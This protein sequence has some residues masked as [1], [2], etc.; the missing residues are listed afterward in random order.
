[1]GCRPSKSASAPASAQ[2]HAPAKQ[3]QRQFSFGIISD[4]QYCDMDDFR[5]S[6]AGEVR[7]Y[8]DSIKHLRKGVQLWNKSHPYFVAQLGDLIDEKNKRLQGQDAA[9][10]A[11]GEVMG[12]FAK[13]EMP[14]LH[15]MGNH[16][17]NNFNWMELR[18]MFHTPQ[19]EPSRGSFCVHKAAES[20]PP[21]QVT[22]ADFR[23]VYRPAAGWAVIVLN[24]YE[25][26]VL[27]PMQCKGFVLAKASI[28][29]HNPNAK[30]LFATYPD[31]PY[32]PSVNACK[33]LAS[34]QYEARF[35]HINGGV[36][37]QA[38][39]WLRQEV[40]TA[41]Q[42]DERILVLTHLPLDPESCPGGHRRLLLY[43]AE[44]VMKI[45]GEEGCGHVVAV[46][47]GHEH[48]GGYTCDRYGIHH[49]TLQSPLTHTDAFGCVDVFAD[50]LEIHGQAHQYG[51][52]WAQAGGDRPTKG[53]EI[54]NEALSTALR[55]RSSFT[56]QEVD[57]FGV[58]LLSNK[59]YF[60]RVGDE[61]YTPIPGGIPSRKGDSA[62]RHPP[63]QGKIAR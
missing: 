56:E 11:A 33:D 29:K 22:A 21:E 32:D 49:I 16:D 18:N 30:A 63:K 5:S 25:V 55:D 57:G 6:T 52:K 7:K 34:Q 43:D 3:E 19:P 40:A 53:V 15:C 20:K 23:F 47:A 24:A 48:K 10:K 42:K 50:R 58:E 37:E 14:V 54:T 13:C 31:H 28:E 9:H 46:F 27:Q 41:L 12:E 17:L 61:Y 2:G 45:L 36:G 26:S 38:L 39:D 59:E 35:W 51:T 60:I 4:I 8:R 62:L 44:D 1:M